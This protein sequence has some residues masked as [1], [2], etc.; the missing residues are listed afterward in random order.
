MFT[1]EDNIRQDLKTVGCQ[2][3]EWVQ[4]AGLVTGTSSGLT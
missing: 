4:L 3:I 1:C 2:N